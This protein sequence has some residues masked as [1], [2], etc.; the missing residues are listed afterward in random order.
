[1]V[2]EIDLNLIQLGYANIRKLLTS[3]KFIEKKESV[4]V[5]LRGTRMGPANSGKPISEDD[6]KQ[7]LD[8][9]KSE[10]IEPNFKKIK[11]E[12]NEIEELVELSSEN[13]RFYSKYLFEKIRCDIGF[14]T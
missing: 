7:I 2:S 9:L 5:Y 8:E 14:R 12:T 4:G 1:M 3:L 10:Q 13:V 6:Y 11:D